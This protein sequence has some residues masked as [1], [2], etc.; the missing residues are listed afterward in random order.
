MLQPQ[1]QNGVDSLLPFTVEGQRDGAV[2]QPSVQFG[3]ERA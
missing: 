2:A 1:P 3:R